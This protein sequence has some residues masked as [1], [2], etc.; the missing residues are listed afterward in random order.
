M[1]PPGL[2]RRTRPCSSP[3]WYDW[4]EGTEALDEQRPHQAMCRRTCVR[5]SVQPSNIPK[6]LVRRGELQ[7]LVTDFFYQLAEAFETATGVV[8]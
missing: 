2:K 7:E 5:W 4:R 1:Q 3:D 6:L 8:G